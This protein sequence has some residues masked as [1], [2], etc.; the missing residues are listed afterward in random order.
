LKLI[1]A[2]LL[3]LDMPLALAETPVESNVDTRLSIAFSVPDPQL[4]SWL[5]E[6]WKPSSLSGGAAKGANLLLVL[7]QKL[8]VQSPDGQP[9][10]V[11]GTERTVALVVPAR[12]PD[13]NE[14]RFFVIRTYTNDPRGLPGPY[15]NAAVVTLRRH[16][17][18]REGVEPRSAATDTWEMKDSTGAAMY[19]RVAYQKPV[20]TRARFEMKPY[21]AVEPDF[22][23]IYRGEQGIELLKSVPDGVDRLLS[24]EF[25]PGLRELEKLV[26]SNP[27][28]VSITAYPWFL[29][30]VFLP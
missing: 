18:L 27:Q 4:Q 13:A 15:K 10:A 6:P 3:A 19:L 16:L 24:F 22:Y 8:L 14:L 2:L 17:E 7:I 9:L 26:G 29:R 1:A 20:P 5:P 25:R 23:R 30:Q 12:R 21:S 28:V 11:G